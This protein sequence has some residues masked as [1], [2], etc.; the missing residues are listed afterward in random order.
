LES[1][2]QTID[3]AHMYAKFFLEEQ[4]FEVEYDFIFENE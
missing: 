3:V 4:G 2:K 1:E